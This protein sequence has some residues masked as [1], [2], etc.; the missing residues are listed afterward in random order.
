VFLDALAAKK[1]TRAAVA[2]FVETYNKKGVTKQ[3]KFAADGEVAG[4]AVYAYAV[5]DG[6]IVGDIAV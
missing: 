6:K 5:K 1:T 4:D 2:A 3:I